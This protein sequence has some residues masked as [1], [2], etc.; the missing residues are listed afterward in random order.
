MLRNLVTRLLRMPFVAD[1]VIGRALRDD[2]TLPD[3][4]F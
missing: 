1:Y 4:G 3:Y 2:I